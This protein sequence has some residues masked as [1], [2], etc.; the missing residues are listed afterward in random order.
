M[1]KQADE[2]PWGQLWKS[3]R[4]EVEKKRV[5]KEA[6]QEMESDEP[7]LVEK[8]TA[9]FNELVEH[10]LDAKPLT[11]NYPS[12]RARVSEITDEFSHVEVAVWNGGPGG[13]ELYHEPAEFEIFSTG[14][15]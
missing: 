13:I 10:G 8:V 3:I 11:A 12:W 1:G 2:D 15:Y 4:T 14:N 6:D 5:D 7:E 9:V